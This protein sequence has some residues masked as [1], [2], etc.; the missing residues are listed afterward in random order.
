[1]IEVYSGFIHII[2]YY[3]CCI[4][5]IYY[6]YLLFIFI[7]YIY[8]LYLLFI[9]IIYIYYFIALLLYYLLLYYYHIISL[10]YP[11]QYPLVSLSTNFLAVTYS[12]LLVSEYCLIYLLLLFIRLRPTSRLPTSD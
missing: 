3:L 4:I 9:F 11:T 7:I 6:L 8:Y 5:Y 10:S 2:L 12:Y 1:V